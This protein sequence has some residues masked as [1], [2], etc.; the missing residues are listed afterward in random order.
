MPVS[1]CWVIDEGSEYRSN[2]H[3]MEAHEK[4]TLRYSET[5]NYQPGLTKFH[6]EMQVKCTI[7][8]ANYI[9]VT[10]VCLLISQNCDANRIFSNC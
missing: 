10:H 1:L 4:C 6:G 8:M 9:I 7:R 3:K 5:C 2:F